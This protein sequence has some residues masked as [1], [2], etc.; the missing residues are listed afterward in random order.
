MDLR[1]FRIHVNHRLSQGAKYV[2]LAQEIGTNPTTLKSLMEQD[3]KK[4]QDKTRKVIEDFVEKCE[5]LYP[6][7]QAEKNPSEPKNIPE[8][9]DVMEEEDVPV[10]ELNM[11]IKLREFL[12]SVPNHYKVTVKIKKC[13]EK[14]S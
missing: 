10:G 4:L 2:N 7:A 1:K 5:K 3:P 12:A 6:A 14:K 13:Q 9:M 11:V 8:L